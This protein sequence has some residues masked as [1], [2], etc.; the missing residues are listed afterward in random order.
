MTAKK[1]SRKID[2]RWAHK[3]FRMLLNASEPE[4]TREEIDELIPSVYKHRIERALKSAAK[5]LKERK[6]CWERQLI[7][8]LIRTFRPD[9]KDAE[10]YD[11]ET[12]DG[13]ILTSLAREVIKQASDTKELYESLQEMHS[14]SMQERTKLVDEITQCRD[15]AR[16]DAAHVRDLRELVKTLRLSL[17]GEQRMSD[18]L[19][20]SLSGSEI[21]TVGADGD[22]TTVRQHLRSVAKERYDEV[23][24]TK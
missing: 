14:E 13:N 21:I 12:D 20:A 15:L 22:V 7:L 23:M 4:I 3:V 2:E 19:R 8:S 24:G 9:Y 18:A 5:A 17:K 16:E 1:P 6:A 10:T 11:T